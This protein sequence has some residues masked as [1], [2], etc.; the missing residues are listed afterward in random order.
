MRNQNRLEYI[1]RILHKT[2]VIFFGILL[3]SVTACSSSEPDAPTGES[4][5]PQIPTEPEVPEI[6]DEE[7]LNFTQQETFKYFWD[8]AEVNSGAARERFHPNEPSNDPNTVSIGGTGFGLMALLV[9]V[10]RGFITRSES[11][12]RI[13]QIL[14]F[15]ASADRFHGAWP[16]WLNGTNGNVRPFS[17]MDNGG[18]LVETA[19]LAQGLICIKEYFKNGDDAEKTLAN[20]ADALWKGVEWNWYTQGQNSLYWHWSPNFGFD[21]NLELKGYNEVMITYVMAAASPDYAIEKEVYTNGWASNGSITDLT[22]AY[23]IPLVVDHAGNS[24]K[25][26]PLFWAHYSY[27]G[28]NPKS[29]NDDFVNYWDAAVNHSKI[30]YLYCV[31]NPKNYMDYGENCWGLTASYSRN[32]NGSIGYNA[33]SPSNDLGVISPTAAISSMPY[34]PE[35]SLKALR[36]FYQNKDKLLGPAGFYDAFSP[37]NNFWVAEAYLAI[38]QGPE[39]V[40]IENYR[41]GLLWKLFMQNEDVQNGLNKLGFSYEQ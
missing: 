6:S 36:Y 15:L 32:T 12:A 29:L 37:Q 25:G 39:I 8:Y 21:I 35:E 34:T 33:H 7:L 30:N 41:T 16:H 18:D 13:D 1:K 10:E 14:S 22:S 23:N 27:L 17:E 9:G 2:F 26:G 5:L 20:K 3:I 19:F 11:V 40:M 31:D 38:D 24:P 4:E 28:L